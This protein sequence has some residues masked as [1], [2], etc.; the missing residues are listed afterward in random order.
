[1]ETDPESTS[2]SRR[3]INY[4]LGTSFGAILISISYPVIKFLVPPKVA[5]SSQST[6]VAGTASELKPNSGWVFPL[7]RKSTRLNSSH[8]PLSR[9]PS[10]A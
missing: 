7:D 5:Q 9:M 1:M 6:V 3:F 2:V 10:S 8:I 4:M